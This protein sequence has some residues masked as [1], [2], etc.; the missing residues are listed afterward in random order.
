[1]QSKLYTLLRPLIAPVDRFINN[2]TMYK[3][4]L[5]TL[6]SIAGYAIIV[7]LFGLLPFSAL[8]LIG[9]LA[10]LFLVSYNSNL[11][12]AKLFKAPTNAES[13]AITALI[14]FLI[15]SPI[16]YLSTISQDIFALAL[17]AIVANAAK[18]MLAIHKKHIFNPAAIAV[19]LCGF[20]PFVLGAI[21]WVGSLIMLPIVFV[22]GFM[23]VRK[24]RRFTMVGTFLLTAL[25]ISVLVNQFTFGDMK[26]AEIF[27]SWPLIFFAGFMLT[28]PLTTP[29]RRK[30]QVYYALLIAVIASIPF[31][32]G[33][34]YTSP[35]LALIIG[36]LFAYIVSP[37]QRLILKLI[38][39][40]EVASQI[41]HFN[42]KSENEEKL[43]FEPGQYLEWTL[44][45]EHIDSRGNRR[46]FTIA[47]SPTEEMISIG[48]K[49]LAQDSPMK[50]SSFKN[51]LAE[52]QTGETIVASQVAGDF[53]MPKDISIPLVF[54]A[55][56]IGVTPFRSM[57][58]YMIDTGE[59]RNITL[60]YS[61]LDPQELAY[62][63][64]FTSEAAKNLGIKFVPM[65]TDP[66]KIPVDWQGV[67]GFLNKDILEKNVPAWRDRMYYL[68]G[69][70][71]MVESYKKMLAEQGIAGK[72][73]KTDYFPGF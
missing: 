65:I 24:I 15:S 30:E 37:K 23:V 71:V 10:L 13:S 63:E 28:E 73:I 25:V 66:K 52:M 19:Y 6:S 51:H 33:P 56:G 61:C 45:H 41:F 54:V 11:L 43:K 3:L 35:E 4:T 36:N 14:I 44:P 48:V 72:Q 67:N 9:S 16:G 58:K 64:I 20:L 18:Y 68:S 34:F 47:S 7:A 2:I 46:Y 38:D 39:R 27:A 49:I 69:P 53:I 29:P 60:F 5:Y 50:G 32:I 57:V 31:A 59:K 12:F 70:G 42:F 22:A 17:I 40:K 8:S 62:S 1:M 55:G 26:M 21:W